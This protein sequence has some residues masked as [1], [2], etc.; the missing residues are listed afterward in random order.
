MSDSHAC[1]KSTSFPLRFVIAL[2]FVA[3]MQYLLR[4]SLTG[5]KLTIVVAKVTV[6]DVNT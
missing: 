6:H 1:K 2:F 4:K 3:P 5:S